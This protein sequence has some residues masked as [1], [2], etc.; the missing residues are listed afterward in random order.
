M[1]HKVEFGIK[2]R[3]IGNTDLRR[4][5]LNCPNN[6]NRFCITTLAENYS[7]G[8]SEKN[9]C[10]FSNNRSVSIFHMNEPRL[11]LQLLHWLFIV[12]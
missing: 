11:I 3:Y 8:N 6:G 1:L 4:Y 5:R 7:I 9:T 10:S 12:S 2:Q